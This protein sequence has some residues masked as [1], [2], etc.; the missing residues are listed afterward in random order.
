MYIID[1][2]LTKLRSTGDVMMMIEKRKK[3]ERINVY[4]IDKYIY[5]LPIIYVDINEEIS[6]FMLKL[7]F[8]K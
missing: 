1:F 3:E 6:F 5:L 8:F 7:L 2:F 4:I